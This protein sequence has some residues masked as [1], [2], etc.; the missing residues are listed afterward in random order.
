MIAD[1]ACRLNAASKT[2]KTNARRYHIGP[3]AID[4]TCRHL[5][6]SAPPAHKS[7]PGR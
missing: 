3:N 6:I 4:V 1:R 5:Y 7:A 2:Q